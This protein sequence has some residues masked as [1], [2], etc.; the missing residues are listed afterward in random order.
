MS[1]SANVRSIEAIAAFRVAL[2]NFS[3]DAR[4]ALGATDMEIRRMR[5][6]LQRDQLVYWQGQIKRRNELLSIARTEL[7]R[8]RLQASN[9]DAISDTEQKENLRVAQRRLEEAEQKVA[10]IK[11]LVPVFEHATSEYRSASQPLGDTLTGSLINS[12]SLLARVVTS[13]ES[14]LAVAPPSAPVAAPEPKK[15]EPE[16]V[17]STAESTSARAEPE[18]QIT[19]AAA[20]QEPG[21]AEAAG[22]ERAAAG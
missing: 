15:T 7:H 9:S 13:L 17:G 11:R 16:S 2:T 20:G 12:L 6:W 1:D 5:D 18:P 19:S 22:A 8:R 4:N 14:Y 21:A 3:E 10:L